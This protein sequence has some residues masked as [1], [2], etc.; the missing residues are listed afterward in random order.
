MLR[1]VFPLLGVAGI[2]VAQ[3]PCRQPAETP[4]NFWMLYHLLEH[5]Y[6]E[7]A[8]RLIAALLLSDSAVAQTAYLYAVEYQIE[9]LGPWFILRG[10][11]LPQGVLHFL[12]ALHRAQ[13]HLPERI[14]QAAPQLWERTS[15]MYAWAYGDTTTTSPSVEEILRLYFAFWREGHLRCILQGKVTPE[16][17]RAARMI[18]GTTTSSYEPPPPSTSMLQQLPLVYVKWQLSPPFSIDDLFLV[19]YQQEQLRR[20]LCQQKQLACHFRLVPLPDGIEVWIETGLSAAV[21]QRIEE[22]IMKPPIP[23]SSVYPAF[24]SW[25]YSSENL[26]LAGWWSCLWDVSLPSPMETTSKSFRL[27]KP[28]LYLL[29]TAP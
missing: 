23:E 1:I 5:G 8:A 27:R 17:I 16:L 21:R 3:P 28:K 9:R 11:G 13:K 26:Q 12:E 2:T 4:L 24:Y 15:S 6:G 10:Y 20:L 25:L 19:W 29:P 18:T 22:F 7:K 14:T